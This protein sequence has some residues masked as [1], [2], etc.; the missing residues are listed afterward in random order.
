MSFKGQ[1]ILLLLYFETNFS[2]C[3]KIWGH[4]P[5][6][7]HGYGPVPIYGP[8]IGKTQCKIGGAANNKSDDISPTSNLSL[9]FAQP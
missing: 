8:Q 7:P 1:D 5:N 4:T 2:G 3:N 6:S 9:V